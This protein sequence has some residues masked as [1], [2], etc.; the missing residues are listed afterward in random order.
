LSGDGPQTLAALAYLY[1]RD[2]RPARAR[3]LLQELHALS[4][5]RYVPPSNFAV[6]HCGLGQVELSL[7]WLDNACAER[8]VRLTFLRID[9]RWDVLRDHPRFVALA[10]RVGLE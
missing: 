2:G 6:V 4:A 9:R 1:A 7:D 3:S 10:K 8:D 5:Q